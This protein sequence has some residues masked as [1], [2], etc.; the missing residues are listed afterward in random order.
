MTN[1]II[2]V[3]IMGTLPIYDAI[4]YDK[5]YFHQ[6]DLRIMLTEYRTMKYVFEVRISLLTI[7]FHKAW[8]IEN[9][10]FYRAASTTHWGLTNDQCSE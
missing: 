1:L 6:R 10:K 9:G 4:M 5:P 7:C 8:F 3:C 2:A